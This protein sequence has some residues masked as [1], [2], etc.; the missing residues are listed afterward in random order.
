MA[1]RCRSDE[2][3]LLEGDVVASPAEIRVATLELKQHRLSETGEHLTLGFL[4][5]S[6]LHHRPADIAAELDDA[7]FQNMD[8]VASNLGVEVL[9][10]SPVDHQTGL[11]QS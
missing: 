2:V 7:P 6:D 9:G 5:F 8:S 10:I 11:P 1:N 3:H 4:H